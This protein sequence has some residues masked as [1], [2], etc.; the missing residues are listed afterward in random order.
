MCMGSHTLTAPGGPCAV[1]PAPRE[2]YVHS[3]GTLCTW[4]PL[5]ERGLSTSVQPAAPVGLGTRATAPVSGCP[6]HRVFGISTEEPP[7]GEEKGWWALW[8]PHWGH[9]EAQPLSG[10]QDLGTWR[11]S[12]CQVRHSLCLL[13]AGQGARSVLEH[14]HDLP[15]SPRGRHGSPAPS[16]GPRQQLLVWG[17]PVLTLLGPRGRPSR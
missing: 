13:P 7:E 1:C 17:T 11:E 10:E 15:C 9:R 16:Q 4:F 8:Q 5:L 2:L 12:L 3:S 6:S 14:R